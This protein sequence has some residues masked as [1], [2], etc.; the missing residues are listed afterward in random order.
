MAPELVVTLGVWVILPPGVVTVNEPMVA[1]APSDT[2]PVADAFN[3]RLKA[4]IIVALALNKMS[5][6]LSVVMMEWP[7]RVTGALKLISAVGV[8]PVVVIFAATE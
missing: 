8:T 6:L 7:V 2:S 4:P 1:A 5:A 3:V